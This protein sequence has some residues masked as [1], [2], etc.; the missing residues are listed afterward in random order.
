MDVFSH[1]QRTVT[2]V[3]ERQG[4]KKSATNLIGAM[5]PDVGTNYSLGT[6]FSPDSDDNVIQMC[7]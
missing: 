1:F 2:T 7:Q 4:E 5:N 6:F 3:T